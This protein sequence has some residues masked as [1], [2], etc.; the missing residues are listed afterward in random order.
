MCNMSVEWIQYQ[1]KPIL[2]VD[3]RKLRGHEL[4]ENLDQ[5]F[6]VIGKSHDDLVI[7]INEE[8]AY[9]SQEYHD[10]SK[11]LTKA[12]RLESEAKGHYKVRKTAIVGLDPVKAFLL[13]GYN[14]DTEQNIKAFKT[15]AE[16]K[17]WLIQE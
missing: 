12:A 4:I 6:N 7:L 2:Y 8:D 17:E 11:E 3:E 5:T 13:S 14:R 10:R 16:A 15:E 1:G 9:I